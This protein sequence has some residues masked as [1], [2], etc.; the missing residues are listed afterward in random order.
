MV[1]TCF[2]DITLILDA[3]SLQRTISIHLYS[4]CQWNDEEATWE[5]C[6]CTGTER[7]F[8]QLEL[9]AVMIVGDSRMVIHHL[10]FVIDLRYIDKKIAES[11]KY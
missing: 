5:K 6:C 11:Q 2:S 3:Q 1:Q 4:K 7:L 8:L 9:V 10:L